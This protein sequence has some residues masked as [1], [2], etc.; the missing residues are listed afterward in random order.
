M[1]QKQMR[2]TSL[3]YPYDP[4]SDRS[5]SRIA[6][7]FAAL[8]WGFDVVGTFTS[9]VVVVVDVVVVVVVVVVIVSI[10][11]TFVC[12]TLYV[13]VGRLVNCC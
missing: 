5:S 12:K 10:F 9:S 8:T 1:T 7:V 3:V 4:V 2:T 11:V 13:F 6:E